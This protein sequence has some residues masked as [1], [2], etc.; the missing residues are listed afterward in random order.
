MFFCQAWWHTWPLAFLKVL[1][2]LLWDL[3]V[4]MAKSPISKA[5]VLDPQSLATFSAQDIS[6]ALI[7]SL[8]WL[9]FSYT[10]RTQFWLV[11]PLHPTTELLST[12]L[13]RTYP[14][15]V[16]SKHHFTTN[17]T[18]VVSQNWGIQTQIPIT[19]LLMRSVYQTVTWFCKQKAISILLFRVVSAF[20][21]HY[22]DAYCCLLQSFTFAVKPAFKDL[23]C[24]TQVCSLKII[25]WD[26]ILHF[27]FRLN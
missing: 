5:Q 27:L 3:K 16:S 6:E 11:V 18:P 15:S 24:R 17:T 21:S 8:F 1:C 22:Q 13:P 4:L 9:P 10:T 23:E 12:C 2:F 19:F 7:R 25:S 20:A 26:L 14:L